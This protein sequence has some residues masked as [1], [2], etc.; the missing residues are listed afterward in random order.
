MMP[1]DLATTPTRDDRVRRA[2]P[3]VR[4]LRHP[5]PVAP[6]R[7]VFATGDPLTRARVALKAGT[8]LH[9]AI[10]GAAGALNAT[11]VTFTLLDV[12]FATLAFCTAVPDPTGHRLATYTGSRSLENV[13]LIAGA[14]TL[15]RSDRHEPLVH[16]HAAFVDD[17]GDPLGGH[18]VPDACRLRRSGTAFATVFT[19]FAIEQGF[20]P[21]TNHTLF[22]PVSHMALERC[23]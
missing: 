6:R 16:C 13:R 2:P 4:H 19:G 21:E 3:R 23:A 8:T 22:R 18:L 14:A 11:S 17:Q 7:I 1:L 9:D 12:E 15:G 20:D 5:G 10:V